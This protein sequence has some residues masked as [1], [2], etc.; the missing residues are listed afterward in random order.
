MLE[1]LGQTVERR[2]EKDL[3][4]VREKGER[5]EESLLRNQLNVLSLTF[6]ARGCETRGNP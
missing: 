6:S 4:N 2:R 3:V 1:R 5:R